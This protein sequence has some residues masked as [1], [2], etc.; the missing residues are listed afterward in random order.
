MSGLNDINIKIKV[1]GLGGGGGNAVDN[2]IANGIKNV[3]FAIANTDIQAL[4]RSKCAEKILLGKKTTNG[5][6]AG[7][8]PEVGRKACLESETE[9]AESMKGYDM[10]F[11]AA[12][13]G[14]GTG[15]A[16][17]VCFAQVAKEL[18]IL[19][20]AIVTKPF[21]FEGK[22]RVQ[23]AEGGLTQLL[24]VADSTV[25]VS[26]NNLM[27][28]IGRKPLAEAFKV[29]DDTLRNG[30]QAIT[31]LID[32]KALINLDFA[33]V[34]TTLRNQGHAILGI[35]FS[36]KAENAAI[37]AATKAVTPLLLE[38]SIKGANQ[39]IV[40][41]T[42]GNQVTLFD[43]E[44]AVSVIRKSTEND[45]DTIFGVAIDEKMQNKIMVT[46]IAT[47]FSTESITKNVVKNERQTTLARNTRSNHFSTQAVKPVEETRKEKE[48]DLM[49]LDY[50]V[51][52]EEPKIIGREIDLSDIDEYESS[53]PTGFFN[54]ISSFLERDDEEEI[55]KTI[56]SYF[57]KRR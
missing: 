30:V 53:N 1:Y 12:G 47:G 24:E 28:L 23:Q 16:S 54:S 10:V 3:D 34:C 14:G 22:K 40:N 2:M 46:V 57:A 27:G 6:G 42:G 51:S 20:V 26:N 39:A 49:S 17:T 9:I 56:P 55:D 19:S 11:L 15:T 52:K 25:V 29:A 37:E 13:M 45:I 8:D 7:A 32:T 31:D 44:D 48:V 43:A 38:N 21:S 5:L 50:R 41:I 35:G 4:N 33:D 18:G 36:E